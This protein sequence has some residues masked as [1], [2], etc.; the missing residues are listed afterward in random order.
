MTHRVAFTVYY[1]D[2]DALGFVYHANYLKF[3]ERGRSELVA[4]RGRGVADWNAAGIL[5]VVHSA[6]LTFKRPG[7]LGDRIEVVTDYETVSRYRGRFTQR[8]E[9]DGEL[10]VEGT[11]DVACVSPAGALLEIPA[12]FDALR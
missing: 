2:T 12:E 10:L 11:V 7:R 8:V 3:F 6:Q 1:E 4:A 5:I 9:R